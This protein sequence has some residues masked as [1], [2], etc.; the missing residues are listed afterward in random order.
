MIIAVESTHWID[1]IH[2]QSIQTRT[3]IRLESGDSL[4]C[5]A[6]RLDFLIIHVQDLNGGED[7]A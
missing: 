1:Y 4:H 6:S 7:L 3:E 2:R 5:L